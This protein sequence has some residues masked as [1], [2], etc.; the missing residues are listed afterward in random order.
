M[1]RP[2]RIDRQRALKQAQNLFW[3]RGYTATS[4]SALLE[5][6][7]MGA[8]SFYAAFGNKAQLFELAI[9]EYAAY[10]DRQMDSINHDQ[11]GLDVVRAF[12]DQTLVCASDRSR[13]RGCLLVNSAIELEGVE[14]EL[15]AKVVA[16]LREFHAGIQRCVEQA[17]ADGLLSNALS[18][19]DATAMLVT[20]IQGLRVES[21]LGLSKDSARRRLDSLFSTL[22]R[23]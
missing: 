20:H 1:P 10:F 6:T 3:E 11:Y 22:T 2:V 8:G 16:Y 21:R 17:H 12:L 7:G 23:P 9:A 4:M 14:P 13:R 15:H 5:A 19:E 18:V